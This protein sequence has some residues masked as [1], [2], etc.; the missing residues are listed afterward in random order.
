V[1]AA[2]GRDDA[3]GFGGADLAADLGAAFEWEPLFAARGALVIAAAAVGIGLFDVPHLDLAD[4][5]ALRAEALRVR[6]MGFTGKLAIHPAQVA[7]ILDA[8]QP[9]ETEITRARRVL[10]ALDAARGGA[11]QLDGKMIDLPVA[12]AA[13][14]ILARAE[15]RQ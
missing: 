7:P 2:L 13:R 14:R 1:A 9:S 12:N 11:A 6:A 5:A 8:F 3:L 15:P 4:A 10:A